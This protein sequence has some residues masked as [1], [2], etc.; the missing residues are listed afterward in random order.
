VTIVLPVAAA[1]RAP[2]RLRQRRSGMAP[3]L[4]DS[5]LQLAPG[6]SII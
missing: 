1:V 4:N 5:A 6:R 3:A 2:L